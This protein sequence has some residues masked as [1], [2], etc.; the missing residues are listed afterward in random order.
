DRALADLSARSASLAADSTVP[1]LADYPM[2][3]AADSPRRLLGASPLAAHGIIDG[4]PAWVARPLAVG[5]AG[6]PPKAA[7]GAGATAAGATGASTMSAG[8][9]ALHFDGTP[10]VQVSVPNS[11]L[12]LLNQVRSQL[13]LTAWV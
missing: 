12:R 9:K 4:E 5:G 11:A 2:Q 13:T 7:T 1:L 8:A 3:P 6:S 10:K